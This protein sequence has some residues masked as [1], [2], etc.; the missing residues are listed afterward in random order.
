MGGGLTMMYLEG[1]AKVRKVCQ[2]D[3]GDSGVRRNKIP[4]GV[5][6]QASTCLYLA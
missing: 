2:F 1:D 4:L 5:L 6:R 3:N